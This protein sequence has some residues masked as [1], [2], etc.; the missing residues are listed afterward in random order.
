MQNYLLLVAMTIL[1][2][3][4]A[5]F[6]KKASAGDGILSILKSLNFYIGGFLYFVSALI[7]IYILKHLDYSVVL[8]L[9]SITYI[10]TMLISHQFLKEKITTKKIIGVSLI[11]IG[12]IVLLLGNL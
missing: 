8:P 1:G 5:F 6:L 3:F 2:A 7:N 9:T 12:S 4:A 11:L 10:F